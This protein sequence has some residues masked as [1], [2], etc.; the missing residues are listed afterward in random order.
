MLLRNHGPLAVGRSVG[1]AFNNM[2]RLERACRSQLMAQGCNDEMLLPS[3]TVFEKTANMYKPGVR[4]TMPV[5]MTSTTMPKA[6]SAIGPTRVDS[7]KG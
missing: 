1:E 7:M 6:P 5:V 3:R 2:Y 4:R